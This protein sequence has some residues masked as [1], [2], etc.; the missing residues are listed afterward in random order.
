M[1]EK[2]F[3]SNLIMH[4]KILVLDICMSLLLC[5]CMLCVYF[6]MY[7]CLY[8]RLCL[9]VHMPM[10][11]HVCV[12]ACVST[13]L[14]HMCACPC[15]LSLLLCVF[16]CLYASCICVS[17]CELWDY[18]SYQQRKLMWVISEY[19]ILYPIETNFKDLGSM[20]TRESEFVID[21]FSN[22][23]HN[24]HLVLVVGKS[25]V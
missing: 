22:A 14:Y 9:S 16:V 8:V 3:W 24:L 7:V 6:C 1:D 25:R 13:C 11:M 12:P 4:F 15:V 19:N 23:F 20:G 18:Y 5:M 21:L 2:Q 17:V 10:H